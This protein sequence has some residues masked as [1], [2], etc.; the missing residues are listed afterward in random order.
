MATYTRKE[1][2][3]LGAVLAGGTV[4]ARLPLAAA[5]EPAR[6]AGRPDLVV[7][8][9]RVY[10]VDDALPRAEAF[11]VRGDRFLAVGSTDD[12]RNLAAP[13]PR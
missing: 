10:T 11:A 2:L 3:G 1:F 7:I 13:R 6:E 8:N 4:A 5:Q 9:A 12:I